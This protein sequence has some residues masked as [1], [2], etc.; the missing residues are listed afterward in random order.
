MYDSMTPEQSAVKAPSRA[1]TVTPKKHHWGIYVLLTLG[2]IAVV[3]PFLWMLL[4]SFKSPAELAQFPPTWIPEA[5]TLANYSKLFTKLNFPLYFWNST[6]IAVSV[7][8][9]NLIFCSM[10][11]YALAKIQFV[12]RNMIF[13]LIIGTLMVPGSVTLIPL[14]IMIS[15]F[16][17]VNT[18]AAVVLPG[19]ASAFN[20]FLMRQFMLGIPD[21]LLEA[22]RVDGASEFFLF[23]RIAL[24]LCV[25]AFVTMTILTFLASWN[26][27]LWPLIVLTSDQRYNLP[28][29]I[30]TFAIGQYA[31]DDGL[32]MAGAVVVVLPVIFVFLLLQRYFT[33]GIAMTG[34]KG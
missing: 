23:W 12:G 15:K 5:P 33:Q 17:L 9:L 34:L 8:G 3:A 2:L 16:H 4:S 14:F 30:A 24:P 10:L 18:L 28:V 31:S 19:A 25:P 29:A 1:R 20:V 7:T 11:G 22:G 13:V 21:E 27:F 6:V 26:D 32:L